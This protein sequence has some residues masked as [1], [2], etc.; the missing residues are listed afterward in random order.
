VIV[1]PTV[2][3]VD[4]DADAL[5]SLECLLKSIGLRV[6]AYLSPHDFLQGYDP[7]RPGCIVLDV[8]MPGLSGLELQQEL[9]RRGSAPPVVVV[10][11]H[12]DV[13]VCAAAF[14]AGAFDFIEKPVNHQL[15][16]G[17]IQRAIEQDAARRQG[18]QLL[19][20]VKT[21]MARLTPREREVMDMI[22]SGRTLK[23]ISQALGVSIQTASKHRARVLEKMEVTTD[24]ALARLALP[25]LCAG[26]LLAEAM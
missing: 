20:E 4:D 16:L 17:R 7:A 11:G 10:T 26:E 9:L 8:R 13:P 21:R 19:A 3:I 14:R 15:L 2:F 22:A 23:Q 12:G 18:L 25:S 1:D 5:E 24:V 6:E